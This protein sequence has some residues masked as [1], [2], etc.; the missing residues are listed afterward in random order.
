VSPG[1]VGD[2]D[3][4]AEPSSTLWLRVTAPLRASRR[5]RTDVASFSEMLESAITLPWKAVA[6]PSVAELPT[7]QKT[8]HGE[9]PLT[10]TT[11]R[12]DAV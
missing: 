10:S 9:A 8:L 7:C 12:A 1:V 5:P 6:V 3:A 11:E 4:H 2:E